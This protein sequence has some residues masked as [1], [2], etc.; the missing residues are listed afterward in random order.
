MAYHTKLRR[1]SVITASTLFVMTNGFLL[2]SLAG[3]S[4]KPNTQP[5]QPRAA[6]AARET[7]KSLTF[8]PNLGQASRDA[9]FV[10]RAKGYIAL[11]DDNGATL[12]MRTGVNRAADLKLRFDGAASR[13]AEGLNK[14]NSVSNYLLGQD[15]SKWLH[16]IPNYSE[17]RYQEAYPG[18][19]VVFKGD[20]RQIRYDFVVRAGSDPS[21]IRLR[22]D[23]V[24][25]IS[26]DGDDL[27]LSTANGDLLNRQPFAYQERNGIKVPVAAS[28]T[29]LAGNRVGFALGTYDRNRDLII[30]PTVVSRSYFGGTGVDEVVGVAYTV[31]AMFL[32]S[33]SDSAGLGSSGVFQV[34]KSTGPSKDIL[35]TKLTS[36]GQTVVWST[37]VGGTGE[38]I[39]KALA[40]DA[41]GNAY[42]SGTTSGAFPLQAA[43]QPNYAGSIDSFIFKLSASGS[44]LEYSTYLGG[45]G[46]DIAS[47]LAVD[48]NGNAYLVGQ[49]ASANFPTAGPFQST[50]AGG[51]F[52][53]FVTK[54]NAAGS[55]L[56]YSTYFGG[57]GDDFLNDIVL[58]S[59]GEVVLGGTTGSSNLAVSGNAY[60]AKLRG[61][62]DAF[63]AK[64]SANGS[65]ELFAT[66]FGGDGADT[67][68]GVALDSAGDV[69]I[70]GSTPVGNGTAVVPVSEAAWNAA[71]NAAATSESYAAK[72]KSD[73][74]S[75][76][77]STLFTANTGATP[78][79]SV[80]TTAIAVDSSN[81]AYVVGR[82]KHAGETY[83][84]MLVRLNAAATQPSGSFDGTLNAGVLTDGDSKLNAIAVEPNVRTVYVAGVTASPTHPA[85]VLP[86]STAPDG[87]YA[88]VAFKDLV[89]SQTSFD[90]GAFSAGSTPDQVAAITTKG[91]ATI[92]ST[93]LQPPAFAANPTIYL[94]ATTPQPWLK[95]TVNPNVGSVGSVEF[96]VDKDLASQLPPGVYTAQVTHNSTGG[97]DTANGGVVFTVKLT[98]NGTLSLDTTAINAILAWNSANTSVTTRPIAVSA[99]SITVK[100]KVS[101]SGGGNWLFADILGNPV[102]T[103]GS[104]LQIIVGPTGSPDPKVGTYTGSVEVSG[105]GVQTLTIPV[106]LEVKPTYLSNYV[107]FFPS[108]DFPSGA[109]APQSANL[110][111]WSA[112]QVSAIPF[113]ASLEAVAGQPSAA[114]NITV[115]P[116]T[117]TI[118]GSTARTDVV[119]TVNPSG[120]G[121]GSYTNR[122]KI[123]A[124]SAFSNPQYY[125]IYVN[126]GRI[127]VVAPNSTIKYNVVTGSA[128]RVT[129]FTLNTNGGSPVNFDAAVKM[130]NGAGWLK[131]TPATGTANGSVATVTVV[132]SQ[133]AQTGNYTGTVTFKPKGDTAAGVPEITIPVQVTAYSQVQILPSAT[134]FNLTSA[135]G[136][137]IVNPTA[138]PGVFYSGTTWWVPGVQGFRYRI[139]IPNNDVTGSIK[140]VVTPSFG[141]ENGGSW[142]QSWG[143]C[144]SSPIET[145]N[146]GGQQPNGFIEILVNPVGLAKG[147]YNGWISLTTSPTTTNTS[148]ANPMKFPVALTIT[149]PVTV[150][151]NPKSVSFVGTF[152]G[153]PPAPQ[154]FDVVK[155]DAPL[156]QA[157]FNVVSDSPWLAASAN[158]Q[159]SA[160]TGKS[161]VTLTL[162]PAEFAKLDPGTYTA[163]VKVN[164][165]GP[166][167][168][169]SLS[170]PVTLTV[171]PKPV[172]QV[173]TNT[174]EFPFTI[175]SPVP[176]PILVAVAN[177]TPSGAVNYTVNV[178]SAPAGWLTSSSAAST[179]G[180]LSIG[181]NPIGL[182]IGDYAGTVTLVGTGANGAPAGTQVV[183]VH[184]KVLA[185]PLV[186][187]AQAALPFS[188]AIGG[189]VPP[190][191]TSAITSSAAPVQIT[192]LAASASTT[193]GGAWLTA[194]LSATT[195][196]SNLTAS[197][198]ESVVRT[199]SAGTYS[200]SITVTGTNALPVTVPV[201][202]NIVAG[203]SCVFTLTPGS[204]PAA[205][206]T[207]VTNGSIAISS[208]PAGCAVQA[209]SDNYWIKVRSV[210]ASQVTYDVLVNTQTAARNGIITVA[211]QAFGVTQLGSTE[212]KAGRIVSLLYQT[213]LGRDAEPAGYGF[214]ITQ[215][216]E[217]L[218]TA[219]YNSEEFQS[220]S[221]TV[222]VT[223][224]AVLGRMPTYQEWLAD[225]TALRSGKQSISALISKLTSTNTYIANAG[226]AYNS[227]NFAQQLYLNAFG[228]AGTAAE[229]AFWKGIIDSKGPATAMLQFVGNGEYKTLRGNTALITLMY[230][231]TLSRDPDTAGL[232]Y[233]VNEL[234]TGNVPQSL[235]IDVFV[236][237]P[238]FNSLVQ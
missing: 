87:F 155:S 161:P 69:Y 15:H 136:T 154:S 89:A 233:W 186:T 26:L 181:I 79:L 8:E 124:P 159:T 46:A 92:T 134:S 145:N 194:A 64:L 172:L 81:Q 37:Y 85:P 146:C 36:N 34:A 177:G 199:L 144:A 137:N 84:A 111:L 45:S 217:A 9:Q 48:A 143:S 167:A 195:S 180:N 165:T 210:T 50:H 56:S 157:S 128:N 109:T 187:S 22:F 230:F 185:Q 119:I 65:S 130:D 149:D 49:T 174:V 197:L 207:G 72:L 80:D 206:A 73:G 211:G 32:V 19:D 162:I 203:G 129:N 142:L 23:G 90:L 63:I 160:T 57:N 147:T 5:G 47:A 59:T 20:D 53:G 237:S 198:V 104:N 224:D 61:T 117:A 10:A 196:P 54:I 44:A 200:G 138:N 208:T 218:G 238:E 86:M 77:F 14:Q 223:Y 202:L 55:A 70:T 114:N 179:P 120:L 140:N 148:N 163:T 76:L 112:D 78:Y 189:A 108:F 191:A 116:T 135:L 71:S 220:T 40:V 176:Q 226:G 170:V 66:Y 169:N 101:V 171:N 52:D 151:V 222:A 150:D 227:T 139:A 229:I 93:D 219:F 113:T 75:L 102:G 58:T 193:S 234:N 29:L 132:P 31:N 41:A 115:S 205:P 60:Q 82:K 18:I 166:G 83:Q 28:Y 39:A 30:D 184:L 168:A 118:P 127:M 1:G 231:V 110:T 17:V 91:T 235:A 99:G 67:A 178:E 212:M 68:T 232:G 221:Y 11:L 74:S 51:L 4:E 21:M 215:A 121:N 35:V 97:Y 183:T 16:N 13:K 107:G 33:T 188:M 6:A 158:G 216:P 175:G 192:G 24:D 156:P 209:V 153:T 103:S 236:S 38:D 96:S 95:V 131:V 182:A 213:F 88:V 3:L 204:V 42:V 98:V 225:V 62:S 141:T 12:R 106:T 105:P 214:W 152:T 190:A 27:L 228:R 133:M 122:L 173:S 25:R 125:Y 2:Y 123:D 100:T 7:E 43:L 164:V 201:T 94:P 126:V